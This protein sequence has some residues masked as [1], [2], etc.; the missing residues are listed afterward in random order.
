M[1]LV[2]DQDDTPDTLVGKKKE[3]SEFVAYKSENRRTC[4]L[5]YKCYDCVLKPP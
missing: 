4:I 5:I 2:I 1:Q 3:T